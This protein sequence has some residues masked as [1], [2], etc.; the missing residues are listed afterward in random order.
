LRPPFSNR[1]KISDLAGD[2]TTT[3]TVLVQAIV[4]EGKE[5]VAAGLNRWI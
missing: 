4:R 2:G 1:S 5:Y 3:T